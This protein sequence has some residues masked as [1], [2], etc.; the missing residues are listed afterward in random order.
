VCVSG[1][2]SN[3]VSL[4]G[5][6]PRTDFGMSLQRRIQAAPF[7]QVAD[8]IERYAV[9]DFGWSIRCLPSAFP[10]YPRVL[11]F[12]LLR[13]NFYRL[14][15]FIFCESLSAIL[16]SFIVYFRRKGKNSS[17]PFDPWV[18]KDTERLKNYDFISHHL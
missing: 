4:V 8:A 3:S 14:W 9:R 16:L 18:G 11:G 12:V 5:L 7:S 17:H 6:Y 10:L 2:D 1:I 13:T 15:C